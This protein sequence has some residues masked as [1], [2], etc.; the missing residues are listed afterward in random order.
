MTLNLSRFE[1]IVT[2]LKLSTGTRWAV[3]VSGGADS[4]CLTIL[5][6]ELCQKNNIQYNYNQSWINPVY[7]SNKL[8]ETRTYNYTITKE[9]S[10]ES[11][12]SNKVLTKIKEL[13]FCLFS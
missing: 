3:A 4:L 2:S 6:H 8:F 5:L 13:R 1:K 9:T 12:Y 10:F 7:D 11:I